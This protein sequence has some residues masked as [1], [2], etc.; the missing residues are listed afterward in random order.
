EWGWLGRARH[1]QRRYVRRLTLE[2]PGDEPVV[3]VTDLLGADRYPAADLLEV[4]LCRWG[5]ERMFQ[6]VTEGFG[7]EALIGGTPRATVFQFAFCLVLNNLVQVA[8]AWVAQGASEPAAAVSTEK[9]FADVTRQLTALREL[10]APAEAAAYFGGPLTA[11]G[12]R[13]RLRRRL[14]G[15]WK[16]RWRKAPAQPHRPSP[17]VRQRT[18][19]S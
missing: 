18:H 16:E 7:L 5:I 2:R 13:E 14:G 11:A 8:R 9:L 1:R 10:V 12:V 15:L 4:Y 6:Q 3:L 17:K 19:G